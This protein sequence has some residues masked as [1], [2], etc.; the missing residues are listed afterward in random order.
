MLHIQF[1]SWVF[2]LKTRG[3][4]SLVNGKSY[5]TLLEDETE[6]IEMLRSRFI[7]EKPLCFSIYGVSILQIVAV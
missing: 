4:Y 2:S 1:T 7:E 3:H 6:A 5:V